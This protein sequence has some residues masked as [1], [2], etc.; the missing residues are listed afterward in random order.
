MKWRDDHG[1]AE[2]RQQERN[3]AGFYCEKRKSE[4]RD[5]PLW[6]E[7]MIIKTKVQGDEG[8]VSKGKGKKEQQKKMSEGEGGRGGEGERGRR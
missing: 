4:R 7:Q 5:R 3:K 8:G 6:R 2:E 1:R